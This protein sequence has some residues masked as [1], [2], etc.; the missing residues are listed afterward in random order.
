MDQRWYAEGWVS[1]TGN[2]NTDWHIHAGT[3][4]DPPNPKATFW[5][6]GT[7]ILADNQGSHDTNYRP[8]RMR[9]GGAG[10]E[11]SRAE[12]AEVLI[13]DNVL[14]AEDVNSVG[15]LPGGKVRSDDRLHGR[16]RRWLGFAARH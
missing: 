11:N 15:G 10:G 16:S 9:F 3:M 8:G 6:D 7:L 14:S 12:I 2:D 1:T 4:A 5:K 13:Y